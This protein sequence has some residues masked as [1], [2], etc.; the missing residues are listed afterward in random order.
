MKYKNIEHQ[1][2]LD[3]FNSLYFKRST[4]GILD[5]AKICKERLIVYIVQV[6]SDD[7]S[8]LVHSLCLGHK[9]NL[10]ESDS[11]SFAKSVTMHILAVSGLHVGMIYIILTILFSFAGL[12][13]KYKRT[14][15]FLILICL[16][17]YAFVTGLGASVIRA[18][19][20]FTIIEIG[21][22]VLHSKSNGFNSIFASAY[23]QLLIF[24][25]QIMDVGFQLSYLAVLGIL[26]FYPKI[27]PL[28][29]PPH[30]ILKKMWQLSCIS[31]SAT[32]GTLPLTFYYFHTFP[33]WF[34]LS[35]ICLV[36][37]GMLCLISILVSLSL[38]QLPFLGVLLIGFT[39]WI[40]R[41]L[42]KLVHVFSELPLA[43]LNTIYITEWEVLFYLV[44]MP[45]L[46]LGLYKRSIKAIYISMAVVCLYSLVW[47]Y[48]EYERS[49]QFIVVVS[50]LKNQLLLTVVDRGIMTNISS[51]MGRAESNRIIELQKGF[52]HKHYI[53][54]IN[55]VYSVEKDTLKANKWSLIRLDSRKSMF[56]SNQC[57]PIILHWKSNPYGSPKDTFLHI[58]T[59]RNYNYSDTTVTY[60]LLNK[61]YFLIK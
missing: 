53:H 58:I 39:T 36:P 52:I 21:R 41:L 7:I 4:L 50:E 54:E 2:F 5:Y 51:F 27:E 17:V 20:M 35:N 28:L 22:T 46:G 16:W 19:L 6:F 49:N 10:K 14:R 59:Q 9:D 60:K 44:L 12:F 47:A 48:K 3:T 42:L 24:P 11:A 23:L 25:L 57:R 61:K 31:I 30:A 1:L 29:N 15:T 33:V 37:L 34:I 38:C 8:G 18:S 26:F 45:L 32:I 43:Q 13:Q 55:W 40:L 56:I